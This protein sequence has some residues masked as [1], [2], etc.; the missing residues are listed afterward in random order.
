MPQVKTKEPSLGL[1]FAVYIALLLLLAVTVWA[2]RTDLG[3]WNFAA[4]TGIATL[5]AVLI[6]LCFMRVYYAKPLIW[7]ASG[8]GCVWLAI[9]FNLVVSDYWTRG[10]GQSTRVPETAV[11]EVPDR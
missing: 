10:P 5:K 7:L 8:A 1:Y 3:R 6:V 11:Y 4:A 9:L 2:S